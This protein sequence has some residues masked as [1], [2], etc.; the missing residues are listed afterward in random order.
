[1]IFH[2]LLKTKRRRRGISTTYYYYSKNDNPLLP[3]SSS[4]WSWE[5]EFH[6]NSLHSNYLGLNIQLSFL[7]FLCL[8][9]I[10]TSLY[11]EWKDTLF[12]ETNQAK[13]FFLPSSSFLIL[14]ILQPKIATASCCMSQFANLK[15]AKLRQRRRGSTKKSETFMWV[16]IKKSPVVQCRV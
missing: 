15:A 6:S 8:K 13:F 11:R 7:I 4:S 1:M 10:F 14:R 5:I 2:F 12:P 16:Q 9:N 3:S